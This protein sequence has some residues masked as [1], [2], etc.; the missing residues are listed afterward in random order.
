MIATAKGRV[1]SE[2]KCVPSYRRP[3]LASTTAHL[4]DDNISRKLVSKAIARKRQSMTSSA[5]VKSR[6]L[7]ADY[8]AGQSNKNNNSNQYSDQQPNVKTCNATVDSKTGLYEIKKGRNFK[9]GFASVNLKKALQKEDV[10]IKK[11]SRILQPYIGTAP[12]KNDERRLLNLKNC[13]VRT[14]P[15]TSCNQPKRVKSAFSMHHTTEVLLDVPYTHHRFNHYA[16]YSAASNSDDSFIS[17]P[18]FLK[19]SADP[20]FLSDSAGETNNKNTSLGSGYQYEP[21]QSNSNQAAKAKVNAKAVFEDNLSLSSTSVRYIAA[22]LKRDIY[23]T[24]EIVWRAKKDTLKNLGKV[25]K[26]DMEKSR[27]LGWDETATQHKINHID[28]DLMNSIERWHASS[29]SSC[30]ARAV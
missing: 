24:E 8:D 13:D 6:P 9:N 18:S 5:P 23:L 3:T 12:F 21:T 22:K 4:D 10:Q 29:G 16:P 19:S 20:N 30:F 7:L 2:K 28:K 17:D 25:S 11:G 27:K 1:G 15:P 26:Q 14:Y